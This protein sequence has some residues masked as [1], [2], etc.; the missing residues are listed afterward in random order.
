M[1]KREDSR[2]WKK[3]SMSY[4]SEAHPT[5]TIATPMPTRIKCVVDLLRLFIAVTWFADNREF[6]TAFIA[7]RMA[8]QRAPVVPVEPSRAIKR[9]RTSSG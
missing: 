3:G 8:S 9:R 7:S 5:P 2:S 1:R 6:I 4:L